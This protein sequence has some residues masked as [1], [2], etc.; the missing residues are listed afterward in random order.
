MFLTSPYID[1]A[2]TLKTL[3][4][5]SMSAIAIFR[6]LT[7]MAS[8]K[9]FPL[10]DLPYY[11]P[12]ARMAASIDFHLRPQLQGNSCPNVSSFLHRFRFPF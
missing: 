1:Q 6:H 4:A 7:F 11:E 10:I 9:S 8:P 3:S 5:G 2:I 12:I